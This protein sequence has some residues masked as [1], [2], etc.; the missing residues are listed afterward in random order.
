MHKKLPKSYFFATHYQN[1]DFWPL[2]CSQRPMFAIFPRW[3]RL[4]LANRFEDVRK[5]YL[6]PTSPPSVFG[7]FGLDENSG[8][9]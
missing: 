2:A 4:D 1:F 6:N 9:P 3:F 7:I 5:C 8:V